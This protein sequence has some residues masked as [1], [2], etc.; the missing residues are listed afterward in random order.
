MQWAPSVEHCW[1]L[2]GRRRG[3]VWL[4]RR[5]E[6]ALGERACVEF[7]GPWVLQREE[8]LGDVLGFVHTHPDGPARPSERDVRTMRAWCGCFGKPLLCVIASPEGLHAFRFDD[9]RSNG[10]QLAVVELF[11]RYVLVAVD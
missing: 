11:P 6:H 10:T 8:R 7:D 5:V 3:P 9:T 2:V 1:T 4:A